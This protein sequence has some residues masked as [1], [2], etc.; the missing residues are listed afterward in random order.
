MSGIEPTQLTESWNHNIHYHPVAL[1]A[2]PPS[3]RRALDVGCGQGALTRRLRGVVPHVTGIDR[4]ERSIEL[5][6]GHAG[7]GDISYLHAD[8]LTAPFPPES[9][10][11]ITSV[12]SLHHMN[13]TKAFD[14]MRELLRPGG[15]LVVI[16][17]ARVSTGADLALELPATISTRVYRLVANHGQQRASSSAAPVYQSPVL[18]PP[19]HTYRQ[20]RQLAQRELPGVRYRRHLLWRYSLTWTKP[21]NSPQAHVL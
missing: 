19:P 5:A 15:T 10:D 14:R 13:A 20:M 8:F 9:F 17:L 16:G 6:R 18:W 12:A 4:D 7:A 3:C 21:H 11:A 2:L 1:H